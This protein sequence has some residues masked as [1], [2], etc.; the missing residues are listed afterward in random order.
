L[1]SPPRAVLRLRLF[2]LQVEIRPK[3]RPSSDRRLRQFCC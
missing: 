3:A 1:P 2:Y